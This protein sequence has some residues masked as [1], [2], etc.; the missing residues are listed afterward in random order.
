MI[1]R[2]L[3]F[4]FPP[5]KVLFISKSDKSIENKIPLRIIF[6]Y[7]NEKYVYLFEVSGEIKNKQQ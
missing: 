7:R 1:I 3:P 4:R 6:H 5:I 2:F